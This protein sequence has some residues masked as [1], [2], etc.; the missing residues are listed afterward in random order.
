MQQ[1]SENCLRL[2][3]VITSLDKV[4]FYCISLIVLL[5][6]SER[7][8]LKEPKKVEAL[9]MKIISALRDHAI[10]NSEAQKKPNYIPQILGKIPELRSL[11]LEGVRRIF[12]L[13]EEGRIVPAPPLVEKMFLSSLPF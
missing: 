12:Y 13:K 6:I 1:H 7:H 10:Y 2:D 9:Q 5:F 3:E 4:F 8:G 11:S